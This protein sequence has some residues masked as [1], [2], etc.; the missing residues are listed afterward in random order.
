MKTSNILTTTSLV[1]LL[2]SFGLLACGGA[3]VEPAAQTQ[4]AGLSQPT[5]DNASPEAMRHEG[6]HQRGPGHERGRGREGGPPS[7]ERFIERFDANHNGT[8]EASE[9]PERMQ[10]HIADFD[11]S[12][13]SVVT[14]DELAAGFKAK[15]AEHAKARFE[16]KDTNHDGMLEAS[17]V[18]D[19]WSRLS[20]ADANGDQKLTPDELR[21]AF[22]AGKLKPAGDRKHWRH[23]DQGAKGAPGA[24][25][26][27]PPAAPAQ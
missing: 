20:V 4:S 1:A 2:S 22:E 19:K 18:G 15:F 16:K 6:G 26:A 13:D 23:G 8:L 5:P 7:P 17:E 10:Q 27:A 25:P 14:K 9:L 21:T 3:E 11:A 12:G 24:P